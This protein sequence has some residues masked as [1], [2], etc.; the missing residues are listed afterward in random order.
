[1]NMDGMFDCE[2]G[3]AEPL[4]RSLG[5]LP[6]NAQRRRILIAAEASR[7]GVAVDLDRS[8]LV[9]ALMALDACQPGAFEVAAGPRPGHESRGTGNGRSRGCPGERHE[10]ERQ[11]L[12]VVAV[13]VLD[14]LDDRSPFEAGQQQRL[15]AFA[16]GDIGAVLNVHREDRG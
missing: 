16:G 12:F 6:T 13:V 15:V 7:Q 8:E 10:L 9:E 2:G 14:L 3:G 5:I 1:M 11:G 4:S